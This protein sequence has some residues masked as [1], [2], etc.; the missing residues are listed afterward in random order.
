M[1]MI[2]VIGVLI[3]WLIMARKADLALLACS[4][5]S[6][7]FCRSVAWRS[8]ELSVSV[9]CASNRF[10]SV[11]SWHSAILV[12]PSSPETSFD[13]TCTLMILPSFLRC[14]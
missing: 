10:R 6:L 4:A 3:S 1:P 9:T 8:N 13:Q 12:L 2:P 5:A 7:A 14:R 11:M